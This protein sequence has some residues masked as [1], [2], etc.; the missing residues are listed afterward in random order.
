MDIVDW[1]ST[2]QSSP[3]ILHKFTVHVRYN[4]KV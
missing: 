3:Y 1:K 2:E 4:F